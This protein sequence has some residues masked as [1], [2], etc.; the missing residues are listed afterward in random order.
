[1]IKNIQLYICIDKFPSESNKEVLKEVNNLKKV[2]LDNKLTPK[3]MCYY[4]DL[5]EVQVYNLEKW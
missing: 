1:M 2:L 3:F 4:T 5:D